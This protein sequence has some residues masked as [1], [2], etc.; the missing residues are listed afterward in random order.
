M[1]GLAGLAA[2]LA[3]A[4]PAVALELDGD[5]VPQDVG[6]LP[7]ALGRDPAV[8]APEPGVPGDLPVPDPA[9][10]GPLGGLVQAARERVAPAAQPAGAPSEE[11]GPHVA[12]TDL[13]KHSLAPEPPPG[14]DLLAGAAGVAGV[15]A[16]GAG[17]AALFW[18]ALKV[19]LAPLYSRISKDAVLLHGSRENIYRLVKEN[20]GI[21]AHEVAER[22]D[23]AWGTAIHHLKLLEQNGLLTSYRDGRYK[24]FFL[25]GDQRLAQKEAVA[26]LRNDTARRIVEAVVGR[27]GL[28][29]KDV[30]EALG[31]SSSL[32]T[33]HLQRLAEA[34]LVLAHRRGRVVHYEPG[35]AWGALRDMPPA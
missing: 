26:L 7:A 33:W 17:L 15:L 35:P 12:T 24:R 20:P 3:L 13:G 16:L 8:P 21:H 1:R 18:P 10:P 34:G 22:L 11:H 14:Q 31:V 19:A 23:L 4:A 28:I 27:P 32:A 29:Q 25:V 30:C 6:A 2:L 9:L 5:V